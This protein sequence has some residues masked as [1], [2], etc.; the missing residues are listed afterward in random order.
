[1]TLRSQVSVAGEVYRTSDEELIWTVELESPGA[2]NIGELI[3]ETAAG[4]IRRV[5]RAGLIR[6]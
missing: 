6:R 1:M 2:D 3:E 5:S 4:I